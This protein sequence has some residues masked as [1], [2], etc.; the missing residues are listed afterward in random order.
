MLATYPPHSPH[1]NCRAEQE[2]AKSAWRSP[3][4][5][6]LQYV[7]KSFQMRDLYRRLRDGV[8][9]SERKSVP[10]RRGMGWLLEA[11]VDTLARALGTEKRPLRPI[12]AVCHYAD[13]E[14][15]ELSRQR[16]CG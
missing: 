16:H 13:P 7:A 1:A 12:G 5:D 10:N 11:V 3:R 2:A 8:S 4:T 9:E 6:T 15:L 14:T